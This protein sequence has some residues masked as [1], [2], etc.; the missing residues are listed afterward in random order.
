MNHST[1][2]VKEIRDK[3]ARVSEIKHQGDRLA[4]DALGDRHIVNT[5]Q[6]LLQL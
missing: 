3:R 1:M 5:K 6:E 2:K 4:L